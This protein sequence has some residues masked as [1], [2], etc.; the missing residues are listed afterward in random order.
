VNA[1]SSQQL[2]PGNTINGLRPSIGE[3]P[4]VFRKSEF[5]SQDEFVVTVNKNQGN[6]QDQETFSQDVVA[7]NGV[8]HVVDEVLLPGNINDFQGAGSVA[9]GPAYGP[10]YGGNYYNGEPHSHNAGYY[11]GPAYYNTAGIYY[12][13]YYGSKGSKGRNGGRGRGGKG[14]KGYGGYRRRRPSGYYTSY[15]YYGRKLNA[16][17]NNP[18]EKLMSDA[19]FFGTDGLANIE[20][21]I[22]SVKD[23]FAEKSDEN[24]KRRLEA[25]L[26]PDGSVKV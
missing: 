8:I 18:D 9:Y 1:R 5:G 21:K 3:P 17:E 16:N 12:S 4:N 25:M 14:N 19:E 24:R 26:E 7:C 23:E 20:A 2:G 11:G 15:G 22:E 10:S 13:Y 6:V